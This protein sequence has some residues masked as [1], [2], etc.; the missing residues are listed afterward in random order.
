LQLRR[1]RER[2]EDGRV[3]T[4]RREQ[5]PLPRDG[6]DRDRR[7]RALHRL[8]KHR[9]LRY[10]EM[11]SAVRERLLAQSLD[12]DLERLREALPRRIRR[13]VERE[14]RLRVEARTRDAELEPAA[15]EH[16]E[17]C[18]VLGDADRMIEGEDA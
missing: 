11:R 13:N 7:V 5:E 14:M 15:A 3:A 18:R 12:E 10:L 16:V 4:R 6:D 17:R 2:A 1:R 8:R 9:H